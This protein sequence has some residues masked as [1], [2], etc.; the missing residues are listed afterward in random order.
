MSQIKIYNSDIFILIIS[1]YIGVII[2]LIIRNQ[3][4]N[5]PYKY[6]IF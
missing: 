2:G 5:Y 4:S 3:T 1:I 6:I